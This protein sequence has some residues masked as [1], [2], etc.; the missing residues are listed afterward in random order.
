[1]T[2][3]ADELTRQGVSRSDRRELYRYRTFYLTY[4]MIVEA[5]PPPFKSIVAAARKPARPGRKSGDPAIAESRFH[6]SASLQKS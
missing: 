5:L 3:L 1:M 2:G 6:N 4:P